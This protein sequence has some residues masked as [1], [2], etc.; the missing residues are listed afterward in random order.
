MI[1][2]YWRSFTHKINV[3][4]KSEPETIRVILAEID[5]IGETTRYIRIHASSRER[6]YRIAHSLKDALLGR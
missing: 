1:E 5:H 6:A 4:F 3:E 2:H